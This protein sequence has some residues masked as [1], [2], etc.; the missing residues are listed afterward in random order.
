MKEPSFLSFAEVL[1]IRRSEGL[2]LEISLGGAQK[3]TAPQTIFLFEKTAL[4]YLCAR[5][6]YRLATAVS[7]FLERW[8][9]G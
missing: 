6:K 4:G 1:E 8:V 9:S 2:L 7:Q 3:P 5:K